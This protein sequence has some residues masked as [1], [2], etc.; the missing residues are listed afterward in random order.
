MVFPTDDIRG[1]DIV[2]EAVLEAEV[3]QNAKNFFSQPQNQIKFE[4]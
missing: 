2:L 4:S 3:A 1:S